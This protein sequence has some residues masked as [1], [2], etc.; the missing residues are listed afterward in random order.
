MLAALAA[1]A[2]IW[3]LEVALDARQVDG[4]QDWRARLEGLL[5]QAGELYRAQD[6]ALDYPCPIE[7]RPWSITVYRVGFGGW[8]EGGTTYGTPGRP[9]FQVAAEPFARTHLYVGPG[10]GWAIGS[11][12]GN[13]AWA[14][15]GY[16]CPTPQPTCPNGTSSAGY[17]LDP[18]GRGSRAWAVAHELGHAGRLEHRTVT[19][20]ADCSLMAYGSM[21]QGVTC[22]ANGARLTRSDCD[23]LLR[24]ARERQEPAASPVPV[25]WV[26]PPAAPTLGVQ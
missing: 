9:D 2:T 4:I 18:W 16:W 12:S 14:W 13:W 15:V 7:L 8:R 23:G 24:R 5:D 25:R 10:P 26:A 6:H 17:L 1:A 11:P 22:P 19:R 20:E 3:W 21:L